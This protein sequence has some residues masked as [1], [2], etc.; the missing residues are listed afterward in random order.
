VSIDPTE[1]CT[2]TGWPGVWLDDRETPAR[3]VI[4]LLH[5]QGWLTVPVDLNFGND[6]FDGWI[7]RLRAAAAVSDAFDV[8][9]DLIGL[10]PAD[11]IR[12]PRGG[13]RMTSDA[14]WISDREYDPGVPYDEPETGVSSTSEAGGVLEA[15]SGGLVVPGGGWMTT[16]VIDRLGVAGSIPWEVEFVTVPVTAFIDDF[17]HVPWVNRDG[18]FRLTSTEE[19]DNRLMVLLWHPEQGTTKPHQNRAA[20]VRSR[21]AAERYAKSWFKTN[22]PQRRP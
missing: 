7:R 15:V 8:P 16:L 18:R 6:G 20:D 1:G 14:H 17:P 19:I 13:L 21:R 2:E 12:V 10:F 3:Y 5:N 4:D 9:P 11:T 22:Y